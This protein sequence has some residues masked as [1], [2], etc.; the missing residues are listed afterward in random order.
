[1]NQ[2]RGKEPR[3][4]QIF[5]KRTVLSVLIRAN[6]WR[7]GLTSNVLGFAVPLDRAIGLIDL[8]DILISESTHCLAS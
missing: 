1:M 5:E 6:P 4:A 3:I 2:R 8:I 7:I